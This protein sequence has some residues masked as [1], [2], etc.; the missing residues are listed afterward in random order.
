MNLSRRDRRAWRI[1]FWVS[2]VCAVV[3]AWFGVKVAPASEPWMRSALHGAITSLAI[4]TP[5]LLFQI[6]GDSWA[7]LRRLRR[8]PLIAYLALKML[9]YFVAIVGGLLLVRLLLSNDIGEYIQMS[10]VFR[11]SIVFAIGMSVIGSLFF[12]VGT[13]LGLGTLRKLLTGR[14]VHPRTDQMTFLLVDMKNSTGL[15]ERL[16][17]IRFHELLN[18]FFRDVAD[19][20]LEC[21]AEIHK[22]VGDEAILTWSG[23]AGL[24]DGA[25]LSCPF[26]ARDMIERHRARYLERFGAVPEFRA[27]LHCGEIVVGEIGDIRR[28]IAYVG[29]TLNV[30]ARMLDAARAMKRDVL[31]SADLLQRAKMPAS[32]QTDELPM[33]EVRGRAAL[34]AIAALSRVG[35]AS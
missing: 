34:L 29:D 17:P 1:F 23:S 16:G 27:A 6:K 10:P 32:L 15:A 26:V 31:V 4:A 20:A 30:A 2:L 13:L 21:D 22:Y 24:D 8:L 18:E 3:S 25:A 14:Y 28:E 11:Q 7:P 35:A 33:L 9:F 12:E 19:A 5:I